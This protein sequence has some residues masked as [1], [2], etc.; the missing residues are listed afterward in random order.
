MKA[1]LGL[2]TLALIATTAGAQSLTPT[3]NNGAPVAAG[4][5]APR[6][7]FVVR[8]NGGN[9]RAGIVVRFEPHCT[10][11]MRGDVGSFACVSAL[12]GEVLDVV[13]DA[14]GMVRSPQYQ[15]DGANGTAWVMA[16]A[17]VD[18]RFVNLPFYWS[19]GT[20][21][22]HPLYIL[23]GNNQVV[24][25]GLPAQP[26][27]ARVLD[28][29]GRPMIGVPVTFTS[30]CGTTAAPL[31]CLLA[32]VLP[33]L[34]LSDGN[35]YVD[36]AVRVANN[37]AGTYA[38]R[39]AIP[40]VVGGIDFNI[41]NVVPKRTA[42]VKTL[43]GSDAFFRLTDA[44][45]SCSITSFEPVL[46][47]F[48]PPRPNKLALPYG[49]IGMTI[50]NCPSGAK[51]SFQLQHPGAFPEGNR[52]WTARPEWKA[53]STSLNPIEGFWEFSVTDGGEGDSDGLANGK[54]ELL[55]G[56]AYGDPAAPD[57][58]DLWWAG[59]EENGWGISIIQHRDVLFAVIFGYDTVGQPT[60]YVMSG[61]TWNATRDTYTGAI[62]SPRGK[63]LDTHV[64]ADFAVGAPVGSLALTFYD[65]MS[66][67]AII[68]LGGTSTLKYIKRQFFGVRDA[69][70]T[71]RFGDM[72]W[73]GQ[74]R[75]GWGLVLH[76]QFG[77]MF[78][79]MFTYGTDGKPIWY[80]MPS[81]TR[82]A[83]DL[84][85]GT[86]YRTAGST[87]PANYDPQRHTARDAGFFR[88]QFTNMT[89]ATLDFTVDGK[90]SRFNL[91]RMPF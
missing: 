85:E 9:P 38:V 73:A 1:L 55:V 54:I 65:T 30:G 80:A 50:S 77:S 6:V 64:A 61:G 48:A 12:A 91:S 83:N 69:N 53:L 35:G 13:S 33:A 56:V 79:V 7:D 4:A 37:V 24:Q 31:P 71:G 45:A 25:T 59:I 22:R 19:V 62:Y 10:F 36:S 89:A 43:P 8:D 68:T 46:D 78:A 21:V 15:A 40:G 90:T 3:A 14:A 29:V 84:F 72:W 5:V 63:P 34:L 47:A 66:A 20:T 88:I 16:S 39:L 11:R 76:Q 32:P 74:A 82:N 28:D 27:I 57:F 18:G 26:L 52:I 51:A 42:T 17:T 41:T 81:I 70:A 49:L 58:G 44:P 2:L 86:A 67:R 23:S 87:W 75:N 60:W